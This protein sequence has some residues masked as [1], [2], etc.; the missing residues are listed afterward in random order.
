MPFTLEDLEHLENLA[1]AASEG[2]WQVDPQDM[3]TLFNVELPNGDPLALAAPIVGDHKNQQRTANA[4]FIAGLNP[5][6]VLALIAQL[7]SGLQ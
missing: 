2:P 1:T 4:A 6:V 3:G 7:R 5:S